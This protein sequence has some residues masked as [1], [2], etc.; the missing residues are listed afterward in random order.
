MKSRQTLYILLSLLLPFEVVGWIKPVPRTFFFYGSNEK[1]IREKVWEASA[2]A[3]GT[4][5]DTYFIYDGYGD[6]LCVLPPEAAARMDTASS[7]DTEDSDVLQD[8][9][10]LYRY[11]SRGRCTWKKLPGAEHVVYTYDAMDRLTASQDGSQ[12]SRGLW[13]HQS[14]D[15]FGRPVAATL[16]TQPL[17]TLCYDDYDFLAGE[18]GDCQE[19]LQYAAMSAYGTRHTNTRGL[20]TG[21]RVY[22]LGE[23]GAY[24]VHAYYYDERGRIVQTHAT[25]HLGGYEGEYHRY[26][27]TGQVLKRRH[28][29]S[30]AGQP[31][32]TEVYDYTYDHADRL[33]TA[34][35]AINGGTPV[36]LVSNQYDAIGRLGSTVQ[37]GSSALTTAYGYN[38]RSWPKTAS[39]P[40]FSE[41]LFYEDGTTPRWAGGISSQE[42]NADSIIRRYDYAYDGLSRLLRADYSEAGGQHAGRYATAYSYDRQG[43]LTEIVRHGLRG[44]QAGVIQEPVI[45]GMQAALPTAG[46]T[47]IYGTIDSL[48][49]TYQGNRLLAVENHAPGLS[50]LMSPRYSFVDGAH[51]S[52]EYAYDDNGNLTQDLNKGLTAVSY[53]TLNLPE[54]YVFASGDTTFCTYNASGEKL[55]VRYSTQ[56]LRPIDFAFSGSVISPQGGGQG[57]LIPGDPIQVP[58]YE[59]TTYDYCGNLVYQDGTL[60]YLLVDGG[61]VTFTKTGSGANAT[62]TPTY[63]AYL[64][65]HLGSNRV[66]ASASGV[67]EQVYHYY[68]YGGLFDGTATSLQPYMHCN[69]ELD[70]MHGLVWYDSKARTYDPVLGMFPQMDPL[71]EKYHPWS[72][73]VYCMGNPVRY[74]DPDGR[75]AWSK[76]G[77]AAF[78]VTKAVAKNS[79]KALGD[80]TTYADAVSDIIDDVNTLTD[81]NSSGWE[82]VGAVASLASEVLPVSVSDA[83]GI[84]SGIAKLF[85]AK[86]NVG[87]Y[88]HL[89]NPRN[90]GPGKKA[91]TL[92]KK[93]IL[94]ENRKM[95]GGVL[96]SDGDG[97]LL[98]NPSKSEKGVPSAMDQAE[99]DH[100]TPRSK[101]GGNDNQNLQVLSKEENLKKGNR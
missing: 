4:T 93:K 7:W 61:Y 12:R 41:T 77:K 42:W 55:Q 34:T 57:G 1:P 17:R 73:Y 82:K 30:A 26:S 37:M 38:V 49:L 10:Y 21:E 81:N 58:T 24:D 60:R 75:S 91:T 45:M 32:V 86:N 16:G 100:I 78:K 53:N 101:G 84:S 59:T 5:A 46:G 66:V 94:A 63:H 92:Q 98:N 69:K 72:P 74:V 39:S 13:Q 3:D 70:T 48:A 64:R 36:T 50:P 40:L 28:E 62:Y 79:L 31:N 9:A 65:D 19:H 22:R 8:Y 88:G 52:T 43:N 89:P 20:L 35:H 25:N 67:A 2:L 90:Y 85:L 68:P 51:A 96:R 80:A 95:N 47:P 76:L 97:R 44:M 56:T 99:I 18:D 11:D 71:A 33:L 83:K 14:Y 54:R 15:L 23:D 27:F 29:H 6:L 87:K